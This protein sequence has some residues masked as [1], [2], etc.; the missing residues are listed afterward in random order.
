P[1][2]RADFARSFGLP[3]TGSA[4]RPP[5]LPPL[6]VRARRLRALRPPRRGGAG[7]AVGAA[8]GGPAASRPL[9]CALP[10]GRRRL[11]RRRRRFYGGGAGAVRGEAPIVQ[12]D[13]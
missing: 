2:G 5:P 6:R 10:L 3:R 11:L 12:A 1:D 4:P 13:G 7:G 8:A 9:R